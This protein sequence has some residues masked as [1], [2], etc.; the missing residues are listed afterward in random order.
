MSE[1]PISFSA[2]TLKIKKSVSL[3]TRDYFGNRAIELAGRVV[4]PDFQK[5]D[6]GTVMLKAMLDIERPLTIATYTRNPAVI[7]MMRHVS[8]GD[9]YPLRDIAELRTLAYSMPHACV[10]EDG[11]T[12]HF[13]RY[14]GGGLFKGFDPADRP[15][16][17]GEPR[18][19]DV[20]LHL[21]DQAHA[22]VVV[23]RTNI[24]NESTR[25]TEEV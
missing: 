7:K 8:M 2:V 4:H 12:Y 19:K 25:I 22:L 20:F 1:L 16:T 15:I 3:F 10:T 18:L 23:A 21:Q 17:E 5:R 11:A 9:M 6:I 24:S 13:N 14:K